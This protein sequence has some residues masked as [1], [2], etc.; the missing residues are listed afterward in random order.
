MISEASIHKVRVKRERQGK[1]VSSVFYFSGA[2]PVK[3]RWEAFRRKDHDR[4]AYMAYYLLTA[5][6]TGIIMINT[7][8]AG[9]WKRCEL[10]WK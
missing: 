10:C 6:F 5:V 7:F 3:P 1:T 9:R 4:E 8:Y 2:W